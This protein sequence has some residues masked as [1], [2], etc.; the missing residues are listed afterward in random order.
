MKSITKQT[1]SNS[2]LSGLETLPVGKGDR[3]KRAAE[4][5]RMQPTAQTLQLIC[6]Y[7]RTAMSWMDNGNV[8]L[9][10]QIPEAAFNSR[11]DNGR[12]QGPGTFVRFMWTDEALWFYVE[13]EKPAGAPEQNRPEPMWSGS[14]VEFLLAPRWCTEPYADEYE[15]LFNSEGGYTDLH[16]AAGLTLEQALSWKAQGIQWRVLPQLTFH[17]DVNGWAF[18]G[19]IPFAA[20]ELPAPQPGEYWGIGLFR[21]IV[22]GDNEVT[23]LAWSPPL[24]NPPKFHTPTRFGILVFKDAAGEVFSAA[25]KGKTQP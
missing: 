18:V 21:K 15:F 7:V 3:L 8:Q 4:S 10:S 1:S 17:P 19:R 12:P 14:N 2:P 9:W 24:T 22:Q 11:A 23:L 25:N 5:K 16:W 6:P 20:F 13:A